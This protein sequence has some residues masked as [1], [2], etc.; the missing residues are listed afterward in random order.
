MN[1]NQK[2]RP[3]SFSEVVEQEHITSILRKELDTNNV[4]PAYLFVG[5]SGASKSTQAR[6][7]AKELNA[8]TIEI[9]SASHGGAEDIRQLVDAI[10]FKPVTNDSILVILDEAHTIS[11][12]GMS[13]LLLILEQ[14]PKD[15]H[16][17]LCTTEEQK[18]PETIKNRCEVFE[19]LPI[20]KNGI[21]NRLKEIANKEKI[22]FDDLG[23]DYLATIADG[24]MRQAITYL[25]Q[26]SGELETIRKYRQVDK[27]DSFLNLIFAVS[28]KNYT[29]V[30]KIV[31]ASDYKFVESLFS[32]VLSADIICKTGLDIFGNIPD[33]FVTDILNIGAKDKETIKSLR[34]LLLNLQYEG[35]NNP[36]IKQLLVAELYQLMEG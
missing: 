23:I 18:I 25:E 9:D 10:H 15:V 33:V 4:K 36:I 29:E 20:S 27:Y 34:E 19:F 7:M 14:P 22:A 35:R 2:Y 3:Q 6:I 17:I 21:T 31:N 30:V 24:S 16:F 8:Y 5:K 32:F 1:L 28:D 11:N 12:A 13:A 26:Y